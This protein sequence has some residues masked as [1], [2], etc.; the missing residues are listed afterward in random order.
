MEIKI[1]LEAGAAKV[2]LYNLDQL[3]LEGIDSDAYDLEDR[4]DLQRYIED[5]NALVESQELD[6][7]EAACVVTGANPEEVD[8]LGVSVDDG[9]EQELSYD[10]LTLKNLS[11]D[12]PLGIIERAEVGEIFYI[13]S[14]EGRGI[15]DLYT[16][17]DEEEF[18]PEK[19]EMGY[20]D[21]AQTLDTYE[22]LTES[23]YDYLCDTFVPGKCSY[24][25]T[26]FEIDNFDYKPALI[27]GSL[28]RVI[29]DPESGEKTLERLPCPPQLFLDESEEEV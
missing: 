7:L 8:L 25:G 20:Y 9:E 28:Y 6:L 17:S 11:V 14:E 3:E 13:R 24:A 21:C 10:T 1:H 26:P 5:V 15:W 4:E 22:L 27:I 19:I 2:G 23:Y 18:S 29:L 16:E 12:E